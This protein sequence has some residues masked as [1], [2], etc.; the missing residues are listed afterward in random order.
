MWHV[1][2]HRR[3]LVTSAL[4]LLLATRAW[5]SPLVVNGGFETGNFSGWTVTGGPC[6][7]V[8]PNIASQ[9]ICTGIDSGGDPRAHSGIDAAYLGQ[10]GS[11]AGISQTIATTPGTTYD[12]QFWLAN[13][14]YAP[15]GGTTPNQFQV[16]W[17]GATV[18]NSNN[19]PVSGYK[20]YDFSLLATGTQ[21]V[22]SFIGQ[23]NPAYFVLDDVSLT[24]SDP[25]RG[26][27]EP[28]TLALVGVGAAT[29]AARRRRRA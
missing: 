12:L 14:N 27:P 3:V 15:L 4:S 13:T 24:P 18:F 7:F 10:Y 11:L 17:N 28:G 23:Q 22:L 20:L 26:T 21:T 9:G 2:V 8:L 19:M 29:L 1:V 5:A 6:E 25:V 16:T